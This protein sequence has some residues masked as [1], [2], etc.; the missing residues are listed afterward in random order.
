MVTRV[1]MILFFLLV[2]AGISWA[3]QGTDDPIHCFIALL[4]F[5]IMVVLNALFSFFTYAVGTYS[6]KKSGGYGIT[7]LGGVIALVIWLIAGAILFYKTDGRAGILSL[8]SPDHRNAWQWILAVIL[9]LSG[10]V[11]GYSISHRRQSQ[12]SDS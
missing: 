11:S 10:E 7:L 5:G 2:N 1:V 6:L 9:M 8:L 3:T 4:A 12:K